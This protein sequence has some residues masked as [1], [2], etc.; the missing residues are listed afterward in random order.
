VSVAAAGLLLES[1]I[2]RIDRPKVAVVML[3]E[4]S[5]AVTV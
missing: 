1:L 3:E 5:V 4:E 2:N